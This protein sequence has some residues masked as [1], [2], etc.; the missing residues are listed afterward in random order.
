MVEYKDD[1]TALAKAHPGFDVI[2][3]HIPKLQ[4]VDLS[5]LRRALA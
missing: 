1:Q 5:P 4:H 2:L 3:E